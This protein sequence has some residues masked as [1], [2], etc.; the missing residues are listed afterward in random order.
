MTTLHVAADDNGDALAFS[1]HYALDGIR[2]PDHA[3][4]TIHYQVI[5]QHTSQGLSPVA[6]HLHCI[7]QGDNA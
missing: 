7:N 3:S 2:F 1:Q 5:W 6:Q 4:G